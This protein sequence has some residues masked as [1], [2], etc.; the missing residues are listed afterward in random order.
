MVK[1]VP[2]S[3]FRARSTRARVSHR[4]GVMP[5]VLLKARVK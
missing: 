1:T 3:S 2:S 5:M 4:P